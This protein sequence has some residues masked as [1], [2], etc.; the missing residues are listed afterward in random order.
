M[1]PNGTKIKI[2]AKVASEPIAYSNSQYLRLSIYKVYLP[3]Y[4]HIYYGDR[5][6]VEGVVEDGA[7]KSP[8]LIQIDEK[9]GILYQYRQKLISFYERS[10][11][12]NH[13][14]IVAGIVIGSKSG[15]GEKLW[16]KLKNSGTAHVVVASGMNIS[17]VSNFLIGVLIIF[18]NRRKAIYF[19]LIGIW[20]YALISGFD[21][22]IVR[23]SVMASAAFLA[24][25]T[26]DVSI[27]T[28]F[29]SHCVCSTYYKARMGN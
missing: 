26:G 29:N 9:S 17:M 19:A 6:V 13:S 5:V 27:L 22:P 25:Q 10:L 23:A 18:L 11:P 16:D 4:P 21:A 3:L 20:I 15:I 12:Q 24:I 28:D 1:Y 7:L 14:A 2:S 8:K